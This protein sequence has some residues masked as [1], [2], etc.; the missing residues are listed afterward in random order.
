MIEALTG[1]HCLYPVVMSLTAEFEYIIGGHYVPAA[2]ILYFI[3]LLP[4]VQEV[5]FLGTDL[6]PVFQALHD[7]QL[8]DKLLWPH[9]SALTVALP[10]TIKVAYKER[11]WALIMRVIKNWLELGTPISR[12]TLPLQII[13]CGS[14]KQ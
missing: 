5:A 8:T 1:C 14:N 10:K 13:K 7:H 6:I 4:N 3:S 12:I 9:L 2:M 11:I